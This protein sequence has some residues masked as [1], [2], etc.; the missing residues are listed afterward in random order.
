MTSKNK[1]S[2]K[3]LNFY[4]YVISLINQGIPISK[5][6]KEGKEENSI[7]SI[8]GLTK[9]SLN[10]HLS[11]L[12]RGDILIK[13]GYG[14][15]KINPS[16]TEEDIKKKVKKEVKIKSSRGMKVKK[17]NLG[18]K[19]ITN[20]HALEIKFPILSGKIEDSGW[21]IKNKLNNWLPKYK[22][23]KNLGGLTIRNNNNKSI[24][25][26]CKARDIENLNEIDNLAF[27]LRT[28]IT[29]YF[30]SKYSVILDAFECEV[31]NI[32]LATEDKQCN[33]MIRKGDKFELKFKKKAEKIFPKDSIDSK[34][35]IDGSPFTF[36]AETND[37]D[38]KRQYL[39]MP[40]TIQG[41]ATS[42]PLLHEYNQNL[43]LHVEVQK[44]NLE[45]NKEQLKTL[46]LIQKTLKNAK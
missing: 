3:D 36:T 34:A 41:I 2:K 46:K 16:L 27:K 20:L 42:M 45:L 19:P 10:Y 5:I 38:W 14:V 15:W 18:D 43:K 11:T 12:K 31:K 39:R 26:F 29:E 35:W 30:K 37:K 9:Q 40:F 13:M 25:V 8:L 33:Q 1:R 44:S 23:V 22:E 24:T 7:C 28:F 32:N 4:L 17:V 6:N 21:E